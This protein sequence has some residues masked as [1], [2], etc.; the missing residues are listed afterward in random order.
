MVSVRAT[1][2]VKI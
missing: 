1:V 2:K